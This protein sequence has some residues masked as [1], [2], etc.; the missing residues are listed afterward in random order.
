VDE[1]PGEETGLPHV[2]CK[3]GDVVVVVESSVKSSGV[4]RV[5]FDEALEFKL[6]LALEVLRTDLDFEE[7]LDVDET[8][9]PALTL[10]SPPT[11]DALW[12]LTLYTLTSLPTLFL[13]SPVPCRSGIGGTSPPPSPAPNPPVKLATVP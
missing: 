4:G 7:L 10:P 9:L 8:M 3:S 12:L 2:A 11:N 6:A 1:A 5:P 13:T